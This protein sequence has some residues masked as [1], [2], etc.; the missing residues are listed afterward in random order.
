MAKMKRA[1]QSSASVMQFVLMLPLYNLGQCHV[2]ESL[3]IYEQFQATRANHCLA[4]EPTELIRI[5][6]FLLSP[7]TEADFVKRG[8]A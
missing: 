6:L 1:G 4:L 8:M 2:K 5:S 3:T 7:E